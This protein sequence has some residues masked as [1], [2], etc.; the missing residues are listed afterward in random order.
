MSTSAVLRT[1]SRAGR[2]IAAISAATLAFVG[3]VATA[4]TAE[5]AAQPTVAVTP[6]PATPGALQTFAVTI[7]GGSATNV[8]AAHVTVPADFTSISFVSLTADDAWAT[9]YVSADRRFELVVA[10]NSDKISDTQS[11]T[12]RFQAQAPASTGNV[13]LTVA[14]WSNRNRSGT[15]TFTASP[16]IA[17]GSLSQT[18]TFG[19]LAD[20]TFGDADVT[21]SATGGGSGNPVT[22]TA[23]G[24]CTA[25]GTNGATIQLT[26]AGS[27]SVTADQAA[28]NGYTAAPSVT[29]SFTIGKAS[30]AIAFDAIDSQTFGDGPLTLAATGGGS[31][32]PVTFTAS[33]TCSVTGTTLSLDGAGTCTV[34][35]NQAGNTN[36]LAAA[37]VERSFTIAKATAT[38][39]LSGLTHT[40]DGNSH[41]ATVTTVPSGLDG[42]AVTYEGSSTPPTAAGSYAVEATL[43]NDDYEAETATGTLVINAKHITGTFTVDGKTYDGSTAATVTGRDLV[44][45]VGDDDVTLDGGA[46][47][48][49]SKDVGTRTAT[50][51]GAAL[52]G[53]DAGNYVLDS[54]ATTTGA[55]SA[56]PVTGA[57]AASDKTYDGTTSASAGGLPL[58][59]RIGSDDVVVSVVTASFADENA[60][61]DK[62]VTATIELTG[63]DSGNYA[64]SSTTATDA[65]TIWKVNLTG[66]FTADN[67]VY[68]GT[69]AATVHPGAL[70][71]IVG[72]EDV[73][74]DV[75]GA[76]F[77]D[78]NVGTGKVV[79]ATLGL[80]G[81]DI[82]NYELANAGAA[83]TTADITARS[84]TGS[85]TAEDKV[86]DGTTSATI[87]SRSLAAASGS[88]GKIG[89]DDVSLSGGTATFDSAAVGSNKTVTATGFTLTGTD[90][91]NY[92]LA[93]GPWTATA[94]ISPLY[95]GKGFF[96]PVD[97]PNPGIV[98]NSVRGGQ[99]VPLK[100]EIFN[101]A[102]TIEQTSLDVFGSD[103]TKAF[104]AKQVTCDVNAAN[105]DDIEVV[106]TGGTSLRYDSTGGQYIQNWKTPTT[107]NTCYKVW[108]ATVDGTTVGPAYFK[109]KK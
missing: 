90:A 93:A 1:R 54:V 70:S 84:V 28:G 3:L 2:A 96:A 82:G 105:V 50:L 44:G 21:V 37:E 49:D 48:F 14:T 104:S 20:K 85:F 34:K 97:M 8:A 7:T 59:G 13:D 102:G 75:T 6:N 55:I 109:L 57:I 35:A 98:W 76:S 43:T 19:P 74:L 108:V 78:E 66:A 56:L 4:P 61:V 32:N 88:T 60:G 26:G 41:G 72:G 83:T 11:I 47:S 91:G 52:I 80:S 33:G 38:L 36:Y 24:D 86:W 65:A 22:F 87:A 31:G 92:E 40:Y 29:R 30:Q 94:S 81:A 23:S 51:T 107:A 17:V 73:V 68:D 89:G 16:S 95:S 99:T 69:T 58:G 5:A 18:I 67:K 103:P 10:D 42:V 39:S 12:L 63:A 45:V 100:F 27:C 79:T 62:T 9:S 71:G 53:T 25:S 15:A 101:A 64:L 46:A 106:S 77:D